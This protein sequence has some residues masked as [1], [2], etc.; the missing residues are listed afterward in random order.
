MGYRKQAKDRKIESLK[1]ELEAAIPK[2]SYEEDRERLEGGEKG[3]RMS[4]VE[5]STSP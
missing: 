1:V 2:G 4:T 5:V 3:A